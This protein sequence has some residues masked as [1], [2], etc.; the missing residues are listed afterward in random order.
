MVKKD[1]YTQHISAQFNAE[2]E[3]IRSNFLT[4]GGMVEKQVVDAIQSLLDADSNLA[5]KVQAADKQINQMERQID[6]ELVRI[7]ARRQPAASDLRFIIAIGKSITDLERIGDEAAKVARYALA[8]TEEGESPRGYA[9]SRH[10]GNQVRVMVH[11]ALDAFARFDAEL[12]FRVMQDDNVIDAEYKTALRALMTY[13]MEDPRSISRVLN[14][15]WVLRSLERIGDHARNISEQLIFL[16]KG[17][18]VRHTSYDEVERQ[19]NLKKQ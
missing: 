2:L 9:E 19:L 16:V 10:I 6:E 17:S 18:D 14:V 15:M 5:E 11:D 13:M 8:L 12:A 3:D 4:M 7:L 1:D